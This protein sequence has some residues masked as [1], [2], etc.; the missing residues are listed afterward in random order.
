MKK[1]IRIFVAAIMAI[2]ASAC[3]HNNGD[4]GPWYGLWKLESLEVDGSPAPDYDGNQFWAFQND[5]V[6]IDEVI[7]DM[8]YIRHVA[9]WRRE[10]D[11]LLIDFTHYDSNAPST[12]GNYA[13][14]ANL[15]LEPDAVNALAIESL[16]GRRITLSHDTGGKV[17]TYRLRKWG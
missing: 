6:Q 3:T 12:D 5:I 17:Y 4:I 1:A 10:G 8:L 13:P 16:G 9:T 15:G 2:A 7:D 11:I 14:P